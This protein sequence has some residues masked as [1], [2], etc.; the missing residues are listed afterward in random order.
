MKKKYVIS[1]VICLVVAL[2]SFKLFVEDKPEA[3]AFGDPEIIVYSGPNFT[4]KELT[5]THSM[6]DLPKEDLGDGKVFNWND[7]I[8]SVVVVSGTWR[9]FEHGR[10]NTTLDGEKIEHFNRDNKAEVPGW[11]TLVSADS[12]GVLE[13][14][15]P[16]VGGWGDGISSVHLVSDRNLPDWAM[17]KV[18]QI[19]QKM[20]LRSQ[21]KKDK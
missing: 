19:D 13:L 2:V 9:L 10:A 5:L 16:G 18:R 6:F 11:S 7:N 4:G 8:R 15:Q 12:R 14:G 17:S 20:Y 21:Q 3:K 1:G